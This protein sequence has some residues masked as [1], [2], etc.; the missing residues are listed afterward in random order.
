LPFRSEN[1]GVRSEWNFYDY[2]A[3][4]VALQSSNWRVLAVISNKRLRRGNI[5]LKNSLSSGN[6]VMDYEVRG[7]TL[8]PH[9]TGTTTQ[10]F[11]VIASGED[12]TGLLP[13]KVVK[14]SWD[15]PYTEIEIRY[16]RHGNSGAVWPQFTFYGTN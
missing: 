16:T 10:P 12:S 11:H 4:G 1:I 13:S 15:E 3:P 7:R 5:L 6:V 9:Y 14:I 2:G 8:D